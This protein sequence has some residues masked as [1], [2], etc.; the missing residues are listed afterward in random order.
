[1]CEFSYQAQLKLFI[2]DAH[3]PNF[4]VYLYVINDTVSVAINVSL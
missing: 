3:Q 2:Q 1:M 4:N